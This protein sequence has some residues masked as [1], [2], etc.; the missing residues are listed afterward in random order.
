MLDT[1]TLLLLNRSKCDFDCIQARPPV[2]KELVF[3]DFARSAA[4]RVAKQR[5]S[6]GAMLDTGRA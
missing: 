5:V 4:V 1:L 6:E 2:L 3:L